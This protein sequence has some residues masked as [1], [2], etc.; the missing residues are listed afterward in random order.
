MPFAFHDNVLDAALAVIGSA[1]T[2]RICSGASAPTTVAAATTATLASTAV[3]SG[4]FAIADATGGG[5]RTTVAAK[6]NVAVTATGTP[7]HYVLVDSTRVL[8]VTEVDPATPGFTSGSTTDIPAVV[9]T[10]GDP[11]VG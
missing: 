5:R 10:I 3:A 8:A 11:V 4:D 1:T 9:F 6:A 2:L 7:T